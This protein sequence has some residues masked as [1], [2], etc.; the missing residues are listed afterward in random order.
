MENNE[1]IKILLKRLAILSDK[2]EK[3]DYPRIEE[4]CY[5]IR[6][7]IVEEVKNK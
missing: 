6:E 1:I 2:V 4:L 7:I 5:L 3:I